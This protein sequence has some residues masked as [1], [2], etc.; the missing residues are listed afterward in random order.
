MKK[1]IAHFLYQS[2]ADT[3]STIRATDVKLGFLFVVYLAPLVEFN[4]IY[5]VFLTFDSAN[6]IYKQISLL[7]FAAWVSGLYSLFLALNS[8]SNPNSTELQINSH[9][10]F[11]NG[12]LYEVRVIDYVGNFGKKSKIKIDNFISSLPDSEEKII[13]ELSLEIFKLTYIRDIKTKRTSA[14]CLI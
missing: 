8:I 11:Y 2:I 3:Q 1:E 10:R 14:A 9:G 13:E 5:K 4:G 12:D 7:I 6:C